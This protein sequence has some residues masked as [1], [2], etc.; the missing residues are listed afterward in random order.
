MV[1]RCGF[2]G[3]AMG[4]PPPNPRQGARPLDPRCVLLPPATD[5]TRCIPPATA[6]RLAR[7]E[8]VRLTSLAARA[9]VRAQPWSASRGLVSGL[10]PRW[11]RPPWSGPSRATKKGSCARA[12]VDQSCDRGPC[13]RAPQGAR[14]EPPTSRSLRAPPQPPR[15]QHQRPSLLEPPADHP[16]GVQQRTPM[17][18]L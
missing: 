3:I 7:S 13:R 12:L 17:T 18:Q 2:A 16:P 6:S 4:A 14:L 5:A 11:L 1:S 8:A 10:N 15:Q 9:T